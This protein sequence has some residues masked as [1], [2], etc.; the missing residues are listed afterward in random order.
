MIGERTH[1]LVGDQVKPDFFDKCVDE[2]SKDLIGCYL[3][4][5]S[6]GG[7]VGGQIIE[8]EAYCENDPAAH[9]HRCASGRRR[10]GSW[11][12]YRAGGRIYLYPG[13]G[14]L[15]H[16]NFT[17][18]RA[19]LGSAVLIRSLIPTH[20]K[21]VMRERR[22]EYER[23]TLKDDRL[24]CK[25]PGKLWEALGWIDPEYNGEPLISAS[26]HVYFPRGDKASSV[27]VG[28]RILRDPKPDSSSYKSK[29]WPRRYVLA[30]VLDDSE[31][32]GYLSEPMKEPR[33]YSK[34]LLQ[35]VKTGE[36]KAC[37]CS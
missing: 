32:R 26:L 30:E 12:M 6:S 3:L 4:V 23:R 22:G 14:G 21:S 13:R 36:L 28:T 15:W 11:P 7:Q 24:L 8:T 5:E 29:D 37:R 20:G 16:L 31:L 35:E 27:V 10:S 17:C 2:V 9:C 19:G 18:G 34:T 25:G 33:E 1:E